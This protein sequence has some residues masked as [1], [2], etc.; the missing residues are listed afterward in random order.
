MAKNIPIK[1]S[2]GTATV[3]HFSP[4]HEEDWP[5]TINMVITF[6]EAMRLHLGLGQALAKLNSYN[7]HTIAG[8]ETA[9]NLAIFPAKR[10][11]T[12]REGKIKVEE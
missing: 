7:R 4:D 10:R 11:I 2:F 5:A 1:N 6:E 9:I 12:I 3:N 8:R